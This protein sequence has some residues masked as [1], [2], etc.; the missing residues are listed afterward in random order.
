MTASVLSSV[1]ESIQSPL[2][3]CLPPWREN[4]YRLVS[5]WDMLQ[6]NAGSFV[7]ASGSLMKYWQGLNHG[8]VITPNGAAELGSSLAGLKHECE[9]HGLRSSTNQLRR[10]SQYIDTHSGRIDTAF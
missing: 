3:G 5:L 4:P 6:F 7:L 2:P 8:A 10:I 9:R 1:S